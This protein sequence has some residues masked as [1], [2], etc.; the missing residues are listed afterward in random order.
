MNT[1]QFKLLAEKLIKSTTQREAV[2]LHL[3]DE[4]SAYEAE[5]RT[6]GKITNTVARDAKR[7]TELLEFCKSV[8][9]ET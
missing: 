5:K 9:K 6:H 8:V 2:K 1:T 4:L 3:L 7:M